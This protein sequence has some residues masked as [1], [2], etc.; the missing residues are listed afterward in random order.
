[1]GLGRQFWPFDRR[2]PQSAWLP[3]ISMGLAWRAVLWTVAA[4]RAVALTVGAVHALDQPPQ[5]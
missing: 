1:M 3:T 2:L 5:R 4:P